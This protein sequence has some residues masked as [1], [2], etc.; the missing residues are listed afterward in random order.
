M[1]LQQF[2]KVTEEKL[3]SEKHFDQYHLIRRFICGLIASGGE[4]LFL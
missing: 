4:G 1:P 3:F 2:K